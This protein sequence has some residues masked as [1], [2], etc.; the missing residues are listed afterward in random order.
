[1]RRRWA[2]E[3]ILADVLKPQDSSFIDEKD[4]WDHLD[5]LVGRLFEL[6]GLDH[7]PCGVNGDQERNRL[8]GRPDELSCPGDAFRTEVNHLRVVPGDAVVIGEQLDQLLLAEGSPIS[9]PAPVED[10][11]HILPAF[12][13]RETDRLAVEI[14]Q[15]K[16][17][18][19]LADPRC[20]DRLCTGRR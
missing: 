1:M 14:G 9:N 12:E 10:E 15:R 8:A 19:R 2:V 6:V 13:L 4:A 18:G 16:L 3:R 7:H 17:G 5:E 11:Q 20:F